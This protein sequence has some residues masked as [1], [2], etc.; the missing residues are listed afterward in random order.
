MTRDNVWAILSE[1]GKIASMSMPAEK[2]RR[3]TLDEYFAMEAA[4]PEAKLEYRD[5]EIVN[6]RELQALDPQG[7]AGGSFRHVQISG[8]VLACL[9][10]ALHESPCNA[11]GSDLRVQIVSKSLFFYPDVTVVCGKP[12]LEQRS[13]IG[14]TLRNP[15]LLVEVLSPSTE[16]YDRG[17]KFHRYFEIPSL[18]EYVLI[19]QNEPR[20]E[21]YLR[22]EDG[23]WLLTSFNGLEKN[24]RLASINI[25]IPLREIFAGVEFP[26]E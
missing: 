23:T 11:Y 8:N 26:A 24:I 3:Y 6:I 15:K 22:R 21:V 17:I 7:M 9:R 12:D 19:S 20:V 10:T 5:G 14:E 2:P 16:A 1:Q 4:M 18:E 25:E 13:G